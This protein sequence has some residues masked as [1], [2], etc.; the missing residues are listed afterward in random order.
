M[1]VPSFHIGQFPL[2]K[3]TAQN[4]ATGHA[5]SIVV[6]WSVPFCKG[7]GRTGLQCRKLP[8]NTSTGFSLKDKNEA[9]PDKTEHRIGKSAKNRG[10]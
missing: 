7:T 6:H 3:G 5:G 4:R 10:Q 8:I 9:R 1:P 2:V